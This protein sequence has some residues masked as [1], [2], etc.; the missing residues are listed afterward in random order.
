[1]KQFSLNIKGERL[2]VDRPLVMGILNVTP[3]SF[4]AGSRTPANDVEALRLR[5]ERIAAEGADLFDI[6]GYSTRPGAEEVLEAEELRRIEAGIKAARTAAPEIPISVDTFR[7]SV[8]REAVAGLGA[9]IVNDVSGGM[10]D[11]SMFDTVA[12]LR[13]PY[14]LMHMRGTPADM[15][16]LTDYPP[17]VAAGVVAELSGKLRELA[18]R[19]VADVIVDPG[20]G[21]AKTAE[22]NYEL[23]AALPEVGRL[24]DRPML[25]GVSRKSMIYRPLG[26]TPAEA[27]PGTT[28]LNVLALEGGASILRVHDVAEA[29]QAVKVWMMYDRFSGNKHNDSGL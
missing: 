20:F 6:G 23:M 7:A 27:L 11:A 16:S 4:Y 21:F 18:L 5:A 15:L 3:D 19:G 13:C 8:A 10:L 28:A 26:I 14:I 22:Q 2:S 12:D 25:V 1:M 17:G 29:V 24:L 9:D